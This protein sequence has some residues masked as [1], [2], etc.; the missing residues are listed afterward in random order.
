[1]YIGK[2]WVLVMFCI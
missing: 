2:S 1:M